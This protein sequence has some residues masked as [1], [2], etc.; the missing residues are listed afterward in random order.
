MVLGYLTLLKIELIGL[1]V[2]GIYENPGAS[3]M[4]AAHKKLE[5]LVST[6][7]ENELKTFMDNKWGYS[8][9]CC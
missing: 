3:I 5:Q 7:Q 4:I 9:L 2:R 1:K 6:R 8:C